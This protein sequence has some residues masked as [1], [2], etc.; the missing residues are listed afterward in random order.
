M[1]PYRILITG[2]RDWNNRR[3]IDDTLT[4][5]AA[6]NTFHDRT[7]VIVHGACPSGADAMADDWARWHSRRSPLI[8]FERHRANW[9]INGKRAG[10]IRNAHMVQLGADVCLAFIKDSSRGASHTAQLAEQAG[11]PTR[12]WTA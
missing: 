10:F 7:T 1:A 11:I 9:Q 2:S 12:R 6:A 8:E 3:V 4:A 5:L